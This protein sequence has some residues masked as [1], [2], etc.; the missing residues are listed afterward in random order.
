M[1]GIVYPDHGMPYPLPV[2]L[3]PPMNGTA[4]LPQAAPTSNLNSS[5][6]S[7]AARSTSYQAANTADSVFPTLTPSNNGYTYSPISRRSAQAT[8]TGLVALG[9]DPAPSPTSNPPAGPSSSTASPSP[10]Y[11]AGNATQP[12]STGSLLAGSALPPP[13]AI[14][15]RYRNDTG[16]VGQAPGPTSAASSSAVLHASGGLSERNTTL[17]TGTAGRREV[18]RWTAGVGIALGVAIAMAM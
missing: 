8:G 13:P 4:P 1:G 6:T 12:L 14:P 5:T 17:F 7:S 11:N 9:T 3:S 10:T 18:G 2:I 15:A 16:R